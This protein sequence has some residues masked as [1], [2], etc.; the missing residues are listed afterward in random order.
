MD[1]EGIAKRLHEKIW[2]GCK[3]M[4]FLGSILDQCE[5]SIPKRAWRLQIQTVLHGPA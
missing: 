5:S 4:L 1:E 3:Q 2:V